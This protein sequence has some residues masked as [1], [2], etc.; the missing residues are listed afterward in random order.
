MEG[1][2]HA[3][4]QMIGQRLLLDAVEG[5]AHRA[6]LSQHVDTVALL[7]DHAGDATHLALDTAQPGKLGL[8]HFLVHDLNYT[9]VGYTWQAMDHACHA[10][11]HHPDPDTATDPVCGMKVTI[12]TAKNKA[13]HAGHTYYCCSQRCLGK[14]TAEPERYLA[15]KPAEAAAKEM[16]KGTIYTCPMHPEIRQVG[17][18]ACPICGMALE[19]ELVSAD[20]A[21]NAELIDMTR[22]FWIGLALT[23]PVFILEMG[24]HLIGAHGWVDQTLSLIHI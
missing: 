13:E 12:A 23:L 24:A 10:H 3:V 14:F 7:L 6:D 22:R 9:P 4:L 8:L 2:R 17:P 16:P 5:G 1:V 21:P 20:D 15:P 18:G 11:H 19:P